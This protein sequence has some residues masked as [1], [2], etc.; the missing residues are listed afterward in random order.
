[1]GNEFSRINI[2][3]FGRVVEI[4]FILFSGFLRWY[5]IRRFTV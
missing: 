3:P 1:M 5:F 4:A 2:K